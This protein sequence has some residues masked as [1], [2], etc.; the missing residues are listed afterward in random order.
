LLSEPPADPPRRRALVIR[1]VLLLAIVALPGLALRLSRTE[2]AQAWLQRT[3]AA[4]LESRVPG[5]RLLGEVHL[6]WAFRVAAGPVVLEGGRD[7]PL[8]LVRIERVTVRPR[9]GALLSG[10]LEAGAVTLDGVRVDGGLRGQALREIASRLAHRPGARGAASGSGALPDLRFADA[11]LVVA[12]ERGP[13]GR[14]VELGPLQG[15]VTFDRSGGELVADAS[16]RTPGGGHGEVVLRSGAGAASLRVRL[17]QLGPGDLPASIRSALPFDITAGQAALSVDAPRLESGRAGEAQVRLDVGDLALRSPAL[18]AE[19]VG[20]VELCVEGMVRWDLARH[21]AAL[22]HGV[23]TFGRAGRVVA[24]VEL[25]LTG[26]PEPRFELAVRADRLGWE[27]LLAALPPALAPPAEIPAVRGTLSAHLAASGPLRRPSAWQFEGDVDPS[28]LS[29]A[30]GHHGALAL[31]RAFTWRAPLPG[32]GTRPVVVGPASPTYAPLASLPPLLVRA[33][34]TSEDAGFFAH[35]GF[36]LHEVQDALARRDG[37]RRVRG[38]S[39]ISQQL[40]KNLFLTPERT[41]ARKEREALATLALEAS[42]GK[43]RL[44]EIYLN[45]VEWGPGV[46]GIGEAARHWFGKDPRDLTPKEAAFLATVIPNPVRYEMYRRRG[47]LTDAWEGRVRDLL[48]KLKAVEMLSD[49]QL[50]EAWY[51]PLEFARG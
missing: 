13:G 34:T 30:E 1:L 26:R 42:L 19:L 27:D 47:A 37:R 35:H 12:L 41:L 50:Y 32:G 29:P 16:L 10:R 6:D 22:E 3:A 7:A 8:P 31:D 25:A 23:V 51:A 38:A 45:L 21:R 17:R 5:A 9:L 20:P 4:A 18:A 43:R 44:L 15:R 24:G 14:R 48:L 39:T 11:S 33:V 49:A 36:D 2:A 40:A 46:Y 28:G